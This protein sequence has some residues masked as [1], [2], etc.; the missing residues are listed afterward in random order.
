MRRTRR[1]QAGRYRC[2][3]ASTPA[4]PIVSGG[5]YVGADIHRGARIGALAH[6]AQTLVSPT[7][8]AFLEDVTLLDLGTHRLKDFTGLTRVHQLGFG[9]FPPLRTPG[10]IELPAPPTTFVG[11]EHELLE[12]AAVVLDRD[13]RLLTV[14]GSGGAGKTRFAIELARLLADE[15]EGGTVFVPLAP[16]REP[17]LVLAPLAQALGASAPECAAIASALRGRRTHVVLDN[18]EHLLPDAARSRRAAAHGGPGAPAARDEPR[19]APRRR[20]SGGSSCRPLPTTRRSP[21]SS[22][23]P[24][25]RES[26]ESTPAVAE[27]CRRLD[28]LPLALELAAARTG[29]LLPRSCS[30]VFAVGSISFAA[31]ETPTHATPPSGRRSPGATTCSSEEEQALCAGLSVFAAGCTLESAELVCGADLIDL[32]SL[33]DKSLLR[34]RVGQLGEHRFWMLETIR[35]YAHERLAESSEPELLRRR[36]AERMVAVARKAKLEDDGS[37]VL[38][39]HELA[40]AER[41]DLRA[42]LDW[43]ARADVEFGVRLAVSLESFWAAHSPAEGARRLRLLLDRAEAVPSPLQAAALRVLGAAST[44]SGEVDFGV[45]RYEESAAM[46]DALGDERGAANVRVRL[47]L[48]EGWDGDVTRA[49]D[50]AEECLDT[51]RRYEMPRLEAEALSALGSVARAG[52]KLDEA[53]ELFRR[54]TEAAYACGFRWFAANSQLDLVELGLE[55]SRLDEV[56]AAAKD[57]L[58]VARSI[59]DRRL[60]GWL[61]TGLAL[62]EQRRGNL[63]RAGRMW[64]AVTAAAE[65][66]ATLADPELIE[67]AEPLVQASTAELDSAF[68]HGT[69]ARARGSRRTGTRRG[70][71]RGV[72]G[73]GA[74]HAQPESNP[75]TDARRAPDRHGDVPLHGHRR[76]DAAAPCP[77]AGGVCRGARRASPRRSAKHSPPTAGSRSTPRATRSSSP[78]QPRAALSPPPAQDG[79]LG[80]ARS[81]SGW[82]CTRAPT[83]TAEGYVGVD[84]HRGARVAALAHGGQVLSARRRRVVEAR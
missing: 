13:P 27:L 6:G 77:G 59:E 22:T 37:S 20:A 39:R 2:A 5:A 76:F 35:E 10:S 7:T 83:V 51:A 47:A 33:L 49:R 58:G 36:H 55:L 15:A 12:A 69:S 32:E 54:S 67:F 17:G 24:R 41:D 70:S 29:L 56:E 64:G 75:S 66:E 4:R 63:E 72:A 52:G 48:H 80:P 74:P 73:G 18:L 16:V 53:W 21:S 1:S 42:A 3:S 68:A 31:D 62:V 38:Q 28:G 9:E 57:A 11:R 71:H 45:Q 81:P 61:L 44:V 79:A 84:V 23:G 14:V 60:T 19:G 82:E 30:S 34:R 8:A 40:L 78:S 65:H 43:A 26:I 50:L 25:R 46:F